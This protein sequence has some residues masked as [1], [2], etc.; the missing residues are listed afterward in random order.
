M[1]KINFIKFYVIY[2]WKSITRESTINNRRLFN[3]L[4]LHMTTINNRRKFNELELHMT[5]GTP[6]E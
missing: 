3:E 5:W 1:I 2:L 4:E 6:G